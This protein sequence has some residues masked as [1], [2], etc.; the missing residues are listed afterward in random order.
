MENRIE[1]LLAQLTLEEKVSLIAGVDMW[2]TAAV[3]R[4][5][6]PAIKMTDGPVARGAGG[7]S[8]PGSVCFPAGCRA[9]SHLE[10]GLVRQVGEALGH[11]TH[12]KGAAI[13]LAPTVNIHRSPL[14]GRNFECYSEDPFLSGQ[15]ASSVYPGFQSQGVSACI[16]HFVC[17]DSEYKRHS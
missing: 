16:K 8:G 15:M 4:M 6:I 10:S 14:A 7:D 9:G 13:L 2:H 17:N 11:E 12:A 1:D 5:G 3:P